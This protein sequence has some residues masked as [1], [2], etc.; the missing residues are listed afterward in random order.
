MTHR[1]T[2]PFPEPTIGRE[3]ELATVTEVLMTS[4]YQ[5]LLLTG[6]HGTGK[7]RLI[8]CVLQELPATTTACYLSCLQYNTQYQV[9]QRLYELLTGEELA[10]GYQTAQLYNRV[11]HEVVDHEPVLVLDDVGFLLLNDGNELLYSLSRLPPEHAVQL[12]VLSASTSALP[13]ALDARTASSFRPR[14]VSLPPYTS[15]QT[16]QILR[17]YATARE[18]PSVTSEALTEIAVTTEN[19]RLG[20]H[21]LNRAAE[22]TDTETP[23]TADDVQVLRADALQRYRTAMLSALSPH[24]T[25]VLGAIV[26]L[27]ADGRSVYTGEVYDRYTQLCRYRGRAAFSTRRISDFLKHLECLGLITAD[28]YYGGPYGKTRR[29]RL[30][31]LEEL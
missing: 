8:Q 6:P 12:V 25:I 31:G 27:T 10:S 14:H 28:Y 3:D 23:I 1:E 5:H 26:Q 29:I 30:N 4:P 15:E 17:A 19:I 13:T 20:R 11:A 18:H 21:W 2:P 16:R 22:V 24:H 7:T 9:L